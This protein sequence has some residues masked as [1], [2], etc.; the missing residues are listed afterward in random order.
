MYRE[1]KDCPYS[2]DKCKF[3]SAC[4]NIQNCK[5]FHDDDQ[6][7]PVGKPNKNFD[8]PI[9]ETECKFGA[10]CRKR[11]EGKCFFRH[12]DQPQPQREH[13]A[14]R[15][16]SNLGDRPCKFGERC[17]NIATCRFKHEPSPF[18]QQNPPQHNPS[19]IVS[20]P[21][22]YSSSAPYTPPNVTS[23]PPPGQR[24]GIFDRLCSN[25][26]TNGPCNG[27]CGLLHGHTAADNFK[28]LFTVANFYETSQK[29]MILEPYRPE[30]QPLFI[31]LGGNRVRFESLT[32]LAKES[33]N[34]HI[35][36]GALIMK[37]CY[38][39]DLAIPGENIQNIWVVKAESEAGR[40]DILV[41]SCGSAG[42]LVVS[43]KGKMSKVQLEGSVESVAFVNTVLLLLLANRKVIGF[44]Y[45]FGSSEF[46][47][48]G[49]VIEEPLTSLGAYHKTVQGE[50]FAG[51]VTEGHTL[52]LINSQL[53]THKQIF[54]EVVPS[55]L[56]TS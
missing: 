9:G 47:P 43:S 15:G 17:K 41:L 26:L 30:E 33:G 20:S 6:S 54:P 45:D 28:K 1:G 39:Q 53:K 46:R 16:N 52:C 31:T 44:Q 8:K 25:Y 12:G 21:A 49:Q 5:F 36:N 23:V 13:L 48:L 3:G 18:G 19:A 10:T 2:H 32:N 56:R 34:E 11:Q 37:R 4:N 51:G 22:P 27:S 14:P 38:E 40:D 50:W 55:L 29:M 42:Y 35:A 24:L 7:A